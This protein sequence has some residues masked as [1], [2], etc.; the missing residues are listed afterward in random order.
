[1][2]TL[3]QQKLR[4]CAWVQNNTT[5]SS[6]LTPIVQIQCSSPY[7]PFIAPKE[8]TVR[9]SLV[10]RPGET[11]NASS[12]VL[13]RRPSCPQ[14]DTMTAH[15]LGFRGVSLVSCLERSNRDK[16]SKGNLSYQIGVT[17]S[18]LE[19]CWAP[20][21]ERNTEQAFSDGVFRAF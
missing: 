14:K 12:F 10:L 4:A 3:N 16:N 6:Q 18:S 21:T 19:A 15:F 13:F 1:M 17:L 20:L 9:H 11:S 7:L 5:G 2:D 8:F